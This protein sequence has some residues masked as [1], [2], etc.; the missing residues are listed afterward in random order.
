ME[1]DKTYVK[2]YYRRA[3]AYMTLGKFKLALKDFEAVSGIELIVV[4]FVVVLTVSVG[5]SCLRA[6]CSNNAGMSI[7]CR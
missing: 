5:C 2:G 1:L 3:A 4:L 7:F 6:V